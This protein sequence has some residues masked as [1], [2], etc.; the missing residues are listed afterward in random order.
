MLPA[1][2]MPD[3]VETALFEEAVECIKQF[4]GWHGPGHY[5]Y[6]GY[7]HKLLPGETFGSDI[8]R[9]TG[10]SLLRADLLQK[11]AVFRRFGKDSLLLGVLAYNVGEYRL[12]GIGRKPKSELIRKLE[13]G[14][15]NI[16]QEYVSFRMY[17]GKV[18]PSIERRR[19]TEHELLFDKTHLQITFSEI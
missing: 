6:V 11:C 13:N 10:D 18:V 15:R 3:T 9:Q 12:L 19:R 2:P 5:P 1:T 17:N 8:S 4:E 7:G 16:L 14:D